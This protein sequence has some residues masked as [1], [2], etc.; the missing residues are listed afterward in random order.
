MKINKLAVFDLDSTLLSVESINTILNQILENP[1]DKNKLEA[2]RAQGMRG[3][4]DLETSLKQRIALFKGLKLEK[5][6]QLCNAMTWT[7]GA[8]DTITELQQ[9]GYFSVCLSAGFRSVTQRVI[10]ELGMNDYYCNTLEHEK[11]VLTGV[12]SGELMHHE[13]KGKV[14][15]RIQKQLNISPEKTLVVG[16]GAND[17]SM[18]KHAKNRIAFCAQDILKEQA[19]HSIESGDLSDILR[20]LKRS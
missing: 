1:D 16:D 14:L 20:I 13:S 12:I 18:F 5:L 4:I 7:K 15:M 11:G 8:Q 3:E 10:S 9:H 17:L 19:T 6:K 2:I